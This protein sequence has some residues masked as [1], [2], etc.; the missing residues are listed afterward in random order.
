M[1]L[2][3]CGKEY[4][5]IDINCGADARSTGEY[6]TKLA[7]GVDAIPNLVAH[8]PPINKNS[9]SK[10]IETQN[11]E[12]LHL[13]FSGKDSALFAAECNK[14]LCTTEEFFNTFNQCK[15]SNSCLIAGVIKHNN[16]YPMYLNDEKD[17]HICDGNWED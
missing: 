2:Q 14:L 3:G 9:L 4:A 15:N 7:Y 13:V 16:F 10:L 12:K 11:E 17:K 8:I 6:A 1:Y 5:N